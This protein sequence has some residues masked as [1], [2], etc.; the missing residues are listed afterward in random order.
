M[1]LVSHKGLEE[2]PKLKNRKIR[3]YK[4]IIE[5]GKSINNFKN[6]TI[7]HF[8][9]SAIKDLEKEKTVLLKQ[10]TRDTV[11]LVATP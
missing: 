8:D 3:I 6:G 1:Y 5:A 4:E 2:Y 7:R 11:Q 9:E 10:I